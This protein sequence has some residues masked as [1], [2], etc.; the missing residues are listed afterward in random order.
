MSIPQLPKNFG[1]AFD[2]SSLTKPKP[3][4]N[5]PQASFAEAT[6]ENFM[7][8]FVQAS[9]EKPVFLVAYTE[10]AAVTVEIRDLLAKMAEEDKG[11]WKFGAIDVEAQPQLIQALRF[12]S[13]PAAAVFIDEQLLPIP[14]L[15]AREDQLRML[16]AQIFKIAK[17][18]GMKVEVPDVPEPK[19]EPEEAA[20]FSALEK[21]DFSGA[22]MAYRNWLARVPDE[23]MAKIGL[24]QCELR[25]RI[26]A[27]DFERTIK[28]AD[29]KPDSLQDQLMAADI[30]VA[31]GRH[32][33]AFDRLLRSVMSSSGEEKAR[34]KE[35]L[36][37]LFQLVDPRD[38][39]LIK[40]RQSLASALF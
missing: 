26:E 17:E 39:D 25:L 2:L 27:L 33:N 22:A 6:V 8:D 19:L 18:K 7:S 9:K 24:A 5:S 29:A 34:A 12:Q 23:P 21:G 1:R 30:E 28:S 13:L 3:N 32:K 40:A 10:R 15:P 31:T 14:E 11:S 38:P 36:L 37:L 35:H 4:P 20:A 16:L